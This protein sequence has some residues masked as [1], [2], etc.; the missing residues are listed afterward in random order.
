MKSMIRLLSAVFVL[1]LCIGVFNRVQAIYDVTPYAMLDEQTQRQTLRNRNGRVTVVESYSKVNVSS[2][3][4]S[5]LE[6]RCYPK[7]GGDVSHPGGKVLPGKRVD[8]YGTWSATGVFDG[9]RDCAIYNMTH[10]Y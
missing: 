3:S 9:G 6:S 10:Q 5:L 1:V 8:F 7:D 4:I 2:S